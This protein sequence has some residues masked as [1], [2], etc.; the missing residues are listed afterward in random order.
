MI[1]YVKDKEMGD[2]L[3]SPECCNFRKLKIFILIA[4]HPGHRCGLYEAGLINSSQF[5]D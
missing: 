5:F 3:R 4:E 2:Q 1:L